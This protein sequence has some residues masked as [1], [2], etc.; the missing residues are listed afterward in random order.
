MYSVKHK[1]INT[2]R[3][4]LIM[5]LVFP[6]VAFDNGHENF[7]EDEDEQEDARAHACCTPSSAPADTTAETKEKPTR[8][9]T[10][11]INTVVVKNALEALAKQKSNETEPKKG[12][13]RWLVRLQYPK[14]SLTI[15]L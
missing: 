14:Q 9:A 15:L 12:K 4:F 10:N 11:T 13:I 7:L 2:M 5:A 3:F 6:L 8:G 1:S